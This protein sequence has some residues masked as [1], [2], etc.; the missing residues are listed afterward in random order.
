MPKEMSTHVVFYFAA[1][2]GADKAD[3]IKKPKIQQI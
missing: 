2:E 3:E 1:H